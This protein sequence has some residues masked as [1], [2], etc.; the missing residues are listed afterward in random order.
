MMPQMMM[1]PQCQESSSDEERSR[2]VASSSATN[3]AA[4]AAVPMAARASPRREGA[5]IKDESQLLMKSQTFIRGMPK[6]RLSEA[7]EALHESL[8]ATMTSELDQDGL[9]VCLWIFT[10]VKPL[11]KVCDLSHLLE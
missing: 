7:L 8:D 6:W 2:P 5:V 1:M 3:A 10:R 11:Q 4:A 9:L